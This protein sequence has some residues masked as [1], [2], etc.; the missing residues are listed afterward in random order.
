MGAWLDG[1]AWVGE[2]GLFRAGR[3]KRGGGGS[4]GLR[5]GSGGRAGCG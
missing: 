1:R 3:D 5:V 2:R 4:H